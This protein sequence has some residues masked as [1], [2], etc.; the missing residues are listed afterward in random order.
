MGYNTVVRWKSPDFLEEHIAFNLM[1]E[2]CKQVALQA[3]LCLPPASTLFVFLAYYS[4]PKMEV[5]FSSEMLVDFWRSTHGYIPE[6]RPL[7][8]HPCENL[9][10]YIHGI[11]TSCPT[12]MALQPH[13]LHT[14][15]CIP[16]SSISLPFCFSGH[17][18]ESVQLM[19]W[20]P[21]VTHDSMWLTIASLVHIR[22]A[23][24]CQS[25]VVL[26]NLIILPLLQIS[27]PHLDF[28]Y[29]GNG[30]QGLIFL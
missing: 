24:R 3:R 5:T 30:T 28:T 23:A 20:L 19:G 6:G 17:L 21:I 14:W 25:A 29:Y 18:W 11:A 13:I 1:V 16:G 22:Y 15:H 9:I 10:S 26:H 7:H 4:V 8:N 2:A 27:V 12:Y